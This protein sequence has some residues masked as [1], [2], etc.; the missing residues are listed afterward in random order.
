ML[1][2][3]RV[4]KNCTV[5]A[6]KELLEMHELVGG[7]DSDFSKRSEKKEMNDDKRQ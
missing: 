5:L 1:R 2:F 7:D 6:A 4:S 3:K